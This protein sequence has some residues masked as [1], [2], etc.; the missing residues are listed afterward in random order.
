MQKP[1]FDPGL[2]QQVGVTLRRAIEK[3]GQFNVRRKGTTWRDV[4][5]YLHL[6]SMPWAA[7][8]GV[9]FS[10]FLIL[11]T[12]FAVGYY[13]LG[14]N[15]LH[16]G[17]AVET[18]GGAF[19]NDFFFSAQTLTTVGY[20]SVWPQGFGANVLAAL[21]AMFGLM[22]FAL[23]TSLLYGRMARP[24]ARISYSPNMA[25]APY[26]D[27]ASLQFRVV[28][29]RANSITDLHVT[30][31]LMDVEGPPGD[32][33]RAYK[34]LKL[35]RE[36]VLFFPVSWTIVHPIDSESPLY[37]KTAAD[38][39]RSQSEFIILIKGYDDTFNQ[40]VHSRYSYRFDELVWGARFVPA[41]HIDSDGDIVLEVD[42]VG[43]LRREPT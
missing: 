10:G 29:R 17:V 13:L 9:L 40:T 20:G 8:L 16:N 35:E 5:P 15:E 4:H 1:T 42:K 24:S 2:T 36:R 25:V 38:L 27:G 43:E 6:I 23:A 33:K 14:A 18:L 26:L 28:N 31:V 37:G 22:G 41:F 11:N 21:E 12:L 32:L 7:F 30:M 19:M 3:N 34:P 39:E